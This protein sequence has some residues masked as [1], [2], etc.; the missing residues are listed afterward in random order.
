MAEP[1]TLQNEGL[2]DEQTEYRG[3]MSQLGRE[4]SGDVGTLFTGLMAPCA[5]FGRI[6]ERLLLVQKEHDVNNIGSGCN[7]SSWLWI[8][9]CQGLC[10]KYMLV[11][12]ISPPYSL[13]QGSVHLLWQRIEY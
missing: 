10:G 8:A 3:W 7:G 1:S 9:S 11:L 6:D 13:W 12:Y 2:V 5:L 4:P